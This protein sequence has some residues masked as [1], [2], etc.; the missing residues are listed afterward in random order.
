[1][2]KKL[3]LCSG[4]LLAATNVFALSGTGSV[5]FSESVIPI[6][7][8]NP[9]LK[10]FILCNFD[11][12]SDPTGTRL[13]DATFPHLGGASTGPYSMWANWQ[14]LAGPERVILTVDTTITFLDGV[15]HP[16]SGS[17]LREARKVVERAKKVE[18]ESPDPGQPIQVPG[19]VKFA[20]NKQF[21]R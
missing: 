8:T 5:D 3:L 2:K 1:M 7:D 17:R 9:S 13:G 6:L 20:A 4:L 15:G 18:I 10:R 14:G 12:V 21:C 11:V 19:G 16:L